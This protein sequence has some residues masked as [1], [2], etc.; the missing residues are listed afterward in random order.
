MVNIGVVGAT[1]Q[2]GQ[3]MRTLLE[4]RDFPAEQVRFFASARSAGRKLTF[5]GQ[6]IEVEDAATAD[7]SGL[8]IALFSAGATTSRAQA[9]RFAE[10][11]V[12]V[13]DNSSA[14]R[15][16]PEVPLVVSEVNYDRDV[17]GRAR[18]LPKGII[19]NPNCTTMAAM[20]VL[21]PLHDEAG[22]VRMIASTYQAVS[23]SG[24]AGVQE[25]YE[26]AS[27][28]V[29]GSR[30]L[31]LDGRAAQFPPPNKYV[32]PIAFNI[33]PLAGSYVDDGSGETDEDQ[34]L[35]NESRKILGIPELAVSGTCVRVPVYTGHSLSLNVEFSQPLSVERAKELLASA[36]GVKLVDVPTPLD[37]AGI[38]ESLVGRIRQDP[39]VPDGRGLALFVSGDNLRKGAALN[40]I[41]IA[42]LLAAEL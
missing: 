16:D 34:K 15:K 18:S 22:L 38:D 17:R 27:A 41:Q 24:V 6:E 5:R 28:V 2:V 7:P 35:R 13:V 12:I 25:L 36:P 21:K 3:V 4:E 1:G 19:A 30:D 14:W 8:D 20:P 39:G 9:P 11:G 31:V 23:G 42:E 37:A 33:V 26:Q 29:E 40:T 32:A 10:A